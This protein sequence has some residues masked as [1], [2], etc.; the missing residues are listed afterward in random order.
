RAS[1]CFT[2]RQLAF[3]K[4]LMN[5]YQCTNNHIIPVVFKIRGIGWFHLDIGVVKFAESSGFIKVLKND[6]SKVVS[7]IELSWKH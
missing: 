6:E 5:I 3:Y 7:Y 4:M 2:E 1:S